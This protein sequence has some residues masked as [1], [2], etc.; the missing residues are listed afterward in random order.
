MTEKERSQ[1]VVFELTQAVVLPV[2]LPTDKPRKYIYRFSAWANISR[3]HNYK[4]INHHPCSVWSGIYYVAC[5]ERDDGWAENGKLEL[6][7]SRDP[8]NVVPSI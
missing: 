1:K 2:I 6:I 4:Q 3:R 8:V 7:D 5:G